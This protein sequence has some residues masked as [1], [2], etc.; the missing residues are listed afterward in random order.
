VKGRAVKTYLCS[1]ACF[2]KSVAEKF[3]VAMLLPLKKVPNMLPLLAR[4]AVEV[5]E[6][7]EVVGLVGVVDPLVACV[8]L[9]V[10]T[11]LELLY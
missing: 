8:V 3:W 6:V 7:P 2:N 10:G 4:R 11:A 1:I 9:S 5:A